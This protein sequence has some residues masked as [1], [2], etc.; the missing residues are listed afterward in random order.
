MIMNWDSSH[1]P[2]CS[3]LLTDPW[4]SVTIRVLVSVTGWRDSKHLWNSCFK[5][6][7][8]LTDG[9]CPVMMLVSSTQIFIPDLSSGASITS[10]IWASQTN[11]YPL[12]AGAR[13]MCDTFHAGEGT[14]WWHSPRWHL[15]HPA[16]L[17]TH[18]RSPHIGNDICS[19][20]FNLFANSLDILT[21]SS[22]FKS[23]HWDLKD[24]R[25][26]IITLHFAPHPLHFSLLR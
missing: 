19:S 4:Y 9:I 23:S 11:S 14:W 3:L 16:D 5:R 2:R 6:K 12:Q 17:C 1:D 13:G 22:E 20:V 24:H 7:D 26:C 18:W 15:S 21:S 25:G 8:H 10:A